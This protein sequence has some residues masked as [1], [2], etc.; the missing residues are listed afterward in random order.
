MEANH[1]KINDI[2]IGFGFIVVL[3]IIHLFNMCFSPLR[4]IYL[5]IGDIIYWSGYGYGRTEFPWPRINF[6]SNNLI[7]VSG[8][9]V[10]I[11]FYFQI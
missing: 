7:T 11:V 6:N 8:I 3:Y 9:L 4:H 2:Q 5:Y 1:Q 10:I